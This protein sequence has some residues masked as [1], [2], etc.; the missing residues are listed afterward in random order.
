MRLEDMRRSDNVEDRRGL[1]P[2]R[3][4]AGIGIGTLV[5]LVVGYFLG[6][7]PST[8]LNL[9]GAGQAVTEGSAA[10]QGTV[11]TG[12]PADPQGDFAAAVLGETEVVWGK[13][14]AASGQRY[15]PPTL[16]LFNGEVA[17]ACGST[18]SA[19]GP[20][21]C[22][23]DQKL[24]ID[25]DFFNQLATE[26]GAPGAFARAYVIAHEVGHHLQNLLGLTEKSEQLSAGMGATGAKRVSVAV[27]LQADCYA[28]V[29]ANLDQRVIEAG[30]VQQALQAAAAVG[31]DTLQRRMQ[32]RVVPETFTHG[33][34]EQ[35]QR[36]FQRGFA[37]GKIDS[38]D[39]FA[40]GSQL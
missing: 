7:S 5:L 21:Y 22:P 14:F 39:T 6:V 19:A 32:G 27:E 29:W 36:W 20:F 25:L 13:Y 12:K 38:C 16:V 3:A 15:A 24:Y 35:R 1:T 4:G 37:S 9:I 30:E 33:S 26:F 28:G 10:A 31:D 8:M 23:G 2:G 40:A 17:S 34:A 18:S 11:A